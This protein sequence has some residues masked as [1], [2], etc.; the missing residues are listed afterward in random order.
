MRRGRGAIRGRS[1]PSQLNPA[2]PLASPRRR[3]GPRWRFENYRGPGPRRGEALKSGE[4]FTLPAN[5]FDTSRWR[6]PKRPVSGG[7]RSSLP[8]AGR[9]ETRSGRWRFWRGGRGEPAYA[10]RKN[11]HN[12]LRPAR[13]RAPIVVDPLYRYQV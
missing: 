4:R 1:M 6:W 9:A 2:F 11:R 13:Q 10:R 8:S 5:R 3:P 12:I 7:R